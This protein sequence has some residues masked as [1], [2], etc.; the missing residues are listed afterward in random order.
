[1]IWSY[2]RASAV[3]FLHLDHSCRED[4]QNGGV[5]VQIGEVRHCEGALRF[6]DLCRLVLKLSVHFAYEPNEGA[7]LKVNLKILRKDG[8]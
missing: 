8:I 1:M 2:L 4:V 7:D 6:E 3:F 5:Q